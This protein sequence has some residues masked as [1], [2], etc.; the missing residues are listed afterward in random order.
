MPWRQALLRAVELWEKYQVELHGQYPVE[1]LYDLESY[2]ATVSPLRVALVLLVTPLPCL[3]VVTL[4]DLLPLGDPARGLAHSHVF[5]LRTAITTSLL[6]AFV[7]QQFRFCI[8]DLN[9][10]NAQLVLISLLAGCGGTAVGFCLA[11]LIGYPMPFIIQCGGLSFVIILVVCFAVGWGRLFRDNARARRQLRNA[12]GILMVQWYLTLVYPIYNAVFV[13]LR[14][15][16]QAAFALVFPVLKIIG[17]NGMAR[18]CKD[19]ED[20]T[21]EVVVMNIEI[22]HALF[23]TYCMQSSSSMLTIAM[24]MGFD[25]LLAWTSLHDVDVLA[26]DIRRIGDKPRSLLRVFDA[27]ASLDERRIRPVLR[28]VMRIVKTDPLVRGSGTFRLVS[29]TQS[30]RLTLPSLLQ[31]SS[32]VPVDNSQLLPQSPRAAVSSEGRCNSE[33]IPP[34]KG[35]VV[36][37]VISQASLTNAWETDCLT[38]GERLEFVQKTLQLLHLT[39]FVLLIEFVEIII[40]LIY[41]FYL[42]ICFQLPNR[43]YY[44][45]LRDLDESQLR[46]IV[47]RVLMYSVMESTLLYL[48]EYVILIEYV[49][50]IISAIYSIYLEVCFR[51]PNRKYHPQLSS[52]DATQLASITTNVLVYALLEFISLLVLSLLLHN[53]LSVP[54][55]YQLAFVL[56]KQWWLVQFKLTFWMMFTVLQTL[57]HAGENDQDRETN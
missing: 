27:V 37:P 34:V 26:S 57:E 48:T 49:E 19:M 9:M 47:A 15:S 42:V 24:I 18:F 12:M 38:P 3:A 28:T 55:I 41:S 52:V 44:P 22:F 11:Y 16:H 56:E 53:K 39:E 2:S 33:N 35:K 8:D 46:E 29:S 30:R 32:I 17:K 31:G 45:H 10:N 13:R 54:P 51:L 20:A 1:R 25:A 23:T 14:G 40:P 5:W 43:K 4:A 7:V 6:G 21:P 36:S 50:V